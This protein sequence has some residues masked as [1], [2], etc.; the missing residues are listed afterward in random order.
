V[1]VILTLG[2][3][4]ELG[5]ITSVII[6]LFFILKKSTGCNVAIRARVTNTEKFHDLELLRDI[7]IFDQKHDW[8]SKTS[9]FSERGVMIVRIEESLYFANVGTIKELFKKN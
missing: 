2:L 5:L 9:I 3:G 8:F 4:V 7:N 6:S 1:T